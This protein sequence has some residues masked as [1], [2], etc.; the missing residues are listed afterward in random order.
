MNEYEFHE[1][2]SGGSWWLNKKDYEKLFAAGWYLREGWD[3]KVSDW[4]DPTKPFCGGDTP[5]GWRRSLRFKAESLREAVESWESATGHDFFSEGCNCCGAPFSMNSV[6][7]AKTWEYV[8]GD[9]VDRTVVR[10][11]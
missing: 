1:N 6:D 4:D 3:K 2:N 11:W 10:P 7:G 9:S 5:H 8:S